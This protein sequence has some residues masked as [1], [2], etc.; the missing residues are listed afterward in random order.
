VIRN[1]SPASG[2]GRTITEDDVQ[3]QTGYVIGGI[4]VAALLWWWLPG[5]VALLI[6]LGIIAIP[7]VGYA[8]LD[9]TQKRR[10]KNVARKQIGRS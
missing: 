7:A 8:M 5:W 4:A 10:L 9:S 3:R 6:I 1:R 2:A